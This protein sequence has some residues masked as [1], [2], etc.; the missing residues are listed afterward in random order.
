MQKENNERLVIGIHTRSRS[1]DAQ[2]VGKSRGNEKVHADE[3]ELVLSRTSSYSCYNR[4]N[5]YV[6]SRFKTSIYPDIPT[7]SKCKRVKP[8]FVEWSRRI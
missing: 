2:C 8:L 3:K 6:W 5:L 7:A 4:E 1:G